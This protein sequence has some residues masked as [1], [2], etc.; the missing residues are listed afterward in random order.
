MA[1]ALRQGTKTGFQHE[2]LGMEQQVKM[3]GIFLAGYK[4]IFEDE[5]RRERLI[6]RLDVFMAADWPVARRLLYRLPVFIQ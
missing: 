4:I 5:C 3:M 2:S 1:H 6:D